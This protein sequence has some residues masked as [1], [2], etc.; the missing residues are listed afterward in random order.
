MSERHSNLYRLLFPALLDDVPKP[1][2]ARL[3]QLKLDTDIQRKALAAMKV[4]GHNQREF[5][6]LVLAHLALIRDVVTQPAPEKKR[7]RIPLI[8]SPSGQVRVPQIIA[9]EVRS[10]S[11][12]AFAMAEKLEKQSRILRDFGVLWQAEAPVRELRLYAEKLTLLADRFTVKVYRLRHG[13]HAQTRHTVELISFVQG[14]TSKRHW[15][16]L[17]ILLGEACKEKG[18][19]GDRLRKMVEYHTKKRRRPHATLPIAARRHLL[20]PKNQSAQKPPSA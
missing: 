18:I 13:E 6:R 7:P 3:R 5:E 19:T 11:S 1:P 15:D 20:L 2:K 14:V 16:N 9:R 12:F 8:P 4:S 10:A 17:A